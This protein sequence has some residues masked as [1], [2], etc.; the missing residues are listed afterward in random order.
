MAGL[1]HCIVDVELCHRKACCTVPCCLCIMGINAHHNR[2]L[3]A[4]R[5]HAVLL[6]GLAISANSV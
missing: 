5:K 3:A 2:T 1:M 6:L 4:C